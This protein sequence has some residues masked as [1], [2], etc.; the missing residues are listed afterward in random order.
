MPEEILYEVDGRVATVTLNAPERLNAISRR[1]QQE[2]VAA[3]ED[4]ER[5]HGVHVAVVQGAGRAF[6][7]GFHIGA[8]RE[9]DGRPYSPTSDRDNIE[10]G[11]RL[12]LKIPEL[13]LPI[14]A[15]VHGYCIA[16]AT[17]LAAICDVTFAAEDTRVGSGPQLPLGAGYVTAF[18]TWFIGPKRAK[19]FAFPSGDFI[20]GAEAA[21]LGLFN[22]AVPPE[23]LDAYVDD[24]VQRVAKV[25][26]DVLAI[27]K[28]SANRVQEIMGFRTALRSGAELDAIAHFSPD[29][30]AMRESVQ[31]QG[32]R[33]AID[34]WRSQL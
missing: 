27:H 21:E 2:L 11:L 18:W 3:L 28:L 22:E 6:S 17:Q 26:K 12:W 8:Q 16:G 29:V 13:R 14:I 20:T 34:A 31:E 1:M 30:V 9:D 33:G 15:K 5:D 32:V 19:Q 7:T 23:M 25:P 4:A 10:D 24:Y